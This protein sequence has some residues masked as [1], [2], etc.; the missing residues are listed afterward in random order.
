[1]DALDLGNRAGQTEST[2]SKTRKTSAVNASSEATCKGEGQ[3]APS[4]S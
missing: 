3:T 1:V 2:H 4:P